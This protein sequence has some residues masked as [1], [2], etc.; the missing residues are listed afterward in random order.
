MNLF[1]EHTARILILFSIFDSPSDYHLI[2]YFYLTTLNSKYLDFYQ[3]HFFQI[4]IK[5]S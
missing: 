3:T 4:F 2:I 1:S 5:D